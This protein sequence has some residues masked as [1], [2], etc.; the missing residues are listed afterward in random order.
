VERPTNFGASEIGVGRTSFLG[1]WWRHHNFYTYFSSS[2]WKAPESSSYRCDSN[3]HEIRRNCHFDDMAA[4]VDDNNDVN[5][6]LLP[7]F[8]SKEMDLVP[9]GTL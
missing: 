1:D 6:A 8:K 9:T 3:G 4:L 2:F 5:K 7:R